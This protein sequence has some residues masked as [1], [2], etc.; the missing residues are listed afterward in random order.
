MDIKNKKLIA[1]VAIFVYNRVLH[2][3][4]MI[5][6]LEE[7]ELVIESDLYIFSDGAKNE[8]DREAV[9]EVREWIDQYKEKSKFRSVYITLKDQNYGLAN[10]IIDGVNRVFLTY[11]KIIVLEDDLLVAKSFLNYMNE[12]LTYYE[13][14]KEVWSISGY[15]PCLEGLE[16]YDKD[17]YFN[18]RPYSWGWATWKDRWELVD[19]K[20]KDYN[21]EKFDI[22]IQKQFMRGGNLMPSMLRAQMN[23]KIDSWYVRWAYEASKRNKLTVYPV[24]SLVKNIGLDGSGTHCDEDMQDKYESELENDV[25]KYTFFL[26][27]VDKELEK[28]FKKFHS[29]SIWE[30]I[31]D[32]INEIRKKSKMN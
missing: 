17:I 25:I 19:W 18:Y 10:S 14:K 32:K 16:K 9:I 3:Q 1:P 2:L 26:D 15:T 20:I 27:K 11:D 30:R 23:G 24:K 12:A 5:E 4:K 7:N 8:K 6:M 31:I 13:E 22:R 29:L 28:E 21:K